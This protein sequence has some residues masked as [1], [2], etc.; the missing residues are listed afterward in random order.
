M[1]A[2]TYVNCIRIPNTDIEICCEEQR[3]QIELYAKTHGIEIVARFEDD[4]CHGPVVERPGVK[5]MLAHPDSY[6]LI[7]VER[8]WCFSRS[9]SEVRPLLEALQEKNVALQSATE[10]WDCLSQQVRHFH[11]GALRPPTCVITQ[12]VP[13][14]DRIGMKRPA[15]LNFAALVRQPTGL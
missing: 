6:D 2:I 13:V 11:K 10:L 12:I 15:R 9:L 8:I 5:A 4:G 14:R 1:K 7:L 3:E